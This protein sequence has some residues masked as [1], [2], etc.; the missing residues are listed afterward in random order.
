MFPSRKHRPSHH[1][2]Y[3][4]FSSEQLEQRGV[5]GEKLT[6]TTRSNVLN[7]QSDV[8]NGERP[9]QQRGSDVCV[10]GCVLVNVSH[11]AVLTE[12]IHYVCN[13]LLMKSGALA[14]DN[15]SSSP[16]R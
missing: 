15:A 13:D 7:K 11:R 4:I 10:L 5:I 6:R 16:C 12:L 14:S 9:L 1:S 3:E 8:T 2:R